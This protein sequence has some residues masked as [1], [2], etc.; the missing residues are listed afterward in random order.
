MTLPPETTG[1]SHV[2]PLGDLRDH[3]VSG[4]SCW[5]RPRVDDDDLVVVHN[6]MDGRE[7]YETGERVMS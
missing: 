1:Y 6:S 2:Y 5:C 3:I 7:K 4:T